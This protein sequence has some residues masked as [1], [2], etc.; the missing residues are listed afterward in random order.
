[1]HDRIAAGNGCAQCFDLQQV[2][3]NGFSWE[4]GEIFEVAGGTDKDA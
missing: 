2:T 4:P 1:M 3:G